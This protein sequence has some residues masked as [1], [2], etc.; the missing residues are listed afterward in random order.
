[1]AI[2]S[3]VMHRTFHIRTS[4][5]TGTAFTIDRGRR[6]YVIT[7]RHVVHDTQPGDEIQIAHRGRWLAAGVDVVGTGAN[8][9]DVAVLT[10]PVQLSPGLP[11]D[12]SDEGLTYGQSV[13]FLGFPLGLDG[14]LEEVNRG[15]PMPFAKAG[16]ISTFGDDSAAFDI[17]AHVNQGFSGG[18]VVFKPY[19]AP[20]NA[21][22]RVAGVI[23]AY[24][25]RLVPIVDANGNPIVNA[26]G[27]PLA[28]VREN[29]GT[30]TA[31]KI[32]YVVDLI[33]SN[34]I[35]FELAG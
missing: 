17:D 3:N 9:E 6:Q 35:G 29:L 34:P 20:Q 33:D 19:G 25:S 18:P 14:G 5:G 12:P 21:A 28:Y 2:T 30:V 10:C 4:S 8:D 31:V 27:Q 22:F 26:Q 1:M 7:A 32:K 15:F 11:L 13:Y 24:R 16:I 23:V